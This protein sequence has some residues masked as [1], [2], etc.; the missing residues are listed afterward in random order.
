MKT[1]PATQSITAPRSAI[2]WLDQESSFKE[3]AQ[4][5]AGLARLQS[6]LNASG[7]RFPVQV[8]AVEGDTLVVATRSASQAALLR[9][10]A[11][12]VLAAMR[13]RGTDL[14]EVRVRV[15]PDLHPRTAPR[16]SARAPISDDTLTQLGAVARQSGESRLA[17][18]LERLIRHQRRRAR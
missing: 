14:R 10:Q 15:R 17:Q 2:E 5:V 13:G 3:L 7:L 11:P 4:R 6:L 1:R 18:A 16:A 12:S 8:L 9:Q